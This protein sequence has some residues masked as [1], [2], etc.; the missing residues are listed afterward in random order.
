MHRVQHGIT[1][2]GTMNSWYCDLFAGKFSASKVRLA[3]STPQ[4]PLPE[5][6]L[7]HNT[8]DPNGGPAFTV[9]RQPRGPTENATVSRVEFKSK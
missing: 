4:P 8:C 9:I 2:A 3:E 7:L 1:F 5:R 6:L